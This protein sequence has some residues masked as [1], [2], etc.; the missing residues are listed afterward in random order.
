MRR[1]ALFILL[2][3]LLAPSLAAVRLD[4]LAR[5]EALS[6]V[7]LA[8]G[9]DGR[10]VWWQPEPGRDGGGRLFRLDDTTAADPLDP[11]RGTP[12]GVAA[13]DLARAAG[14]DGDDGPGTVAGLAIDGNDLIAL[15]RGRVQRQ[16]T[17]ALVRVEGAMARAAGRPQLRVEVDPRT[18]LE[19]IDLGPNLALAG[20]SMHR[21]GGNL[22]VLGRDL[23]RVRLF[24]RP[25]NGYGL[26]TRLDLT[27]ADDNAPP[28]LRRGDV[29]LAPGEGGG[30]LA[31]RSDA[32]AGTTAVW[33]VDVEGRTRRLAL[34]SGLPLGHA[35]AVAAAGSA[36]PV[37][38][39]ADTDRAGVV[40]E[41][42]APRPAA[43]FVLNY[44]A[45]VRFTL[46]GPV[47]V[48]RD[49]L[50]APPTLAVWALQLDT[51][52]PAGPGRLVGFDAASGL[53]IAVDLDATPT[54]APGPGRR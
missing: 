32:D 12:V 30:L 28:D 10:V 17:A 8:G 3:L 49:D 22:F 34:A 39:A 15:W 13:V 43:G 44:P 20:V 31:T 24:H 1:L 40:P 37:T 54:A 7:V 11:P 33:H 35:P 46:D 6:Q 5:S 4:V 45:L 21:S 41:A 9:D 14:A 53:L 23:D 2:V 48:G 52:V 29:R 36:T 19:A 51:L 47:A 27:P 16:T 50:I 26:G 42:P 38:F 25:L 18:F